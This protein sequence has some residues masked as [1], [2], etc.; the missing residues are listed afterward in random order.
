MTILDDVTKKTL[1]TA[2]QY[3]RSKKLI[4]LFFILLGIV[5]AILPVLPGW[6]FFVIGFELLGIKFLV[7]DNILFYLKLKKRPE[8]ENKN[9]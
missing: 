5:G 4:G 2:N 7:V 3:P 8:I 1:D 9:K 6:P